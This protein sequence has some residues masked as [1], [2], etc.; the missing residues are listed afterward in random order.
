MIPPYA[1]SLPDWMRQVAKEFQG[2]ALSNSPTTDQ[3]FTQNN[4]LIFRFGDKVAIGGATVSDYSFPNNTKDW[5]SAFQVAAGLSSGTPLSAHMIALTNANAGSAVGVIGGAQSLNFTNVGTNALANTAYVVNNNATLATNAWA[6]YGEA[7][8]TTAAA[9][10]IYFMEGDT[11]TLVAS[12]APTP[13]QQG[14]VIGVQM[15]SGAGLSATGQFDASAAFQIVPNPMKWKV[16]INFMNNALVDGL[17]I[18]LAAQASN[19]HRIQWKNS[20]GFQ[21]GTI[22]STVT[23]SNAHNLTFTSN[24]LQVSGSDGSAVAYFNPLTGGANWLTFSGN[25]T[26]GASVI[27]AAGTDAN[28]D[29]KLARQG[30]GVAWIGAYTAGAPAAGGF[31]TVKDDTGTVRKLLCA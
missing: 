30:T 9:G 8:K 22:Q 1:P 29:L 23:G 21:A 24:G 19:P 17:A 7:H 15:G 3:I 6:F 2:V 26:G 13:F 4:A 11:R 12:I 28:V 10:S 14:D 31:I 18:H 27:G 5:L 20:G 25:S 16:G